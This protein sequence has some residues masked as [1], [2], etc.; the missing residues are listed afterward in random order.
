MLR[1]DP[2]YRVDNRLNSHLRGMVLCFLGL[3]WTRNEL[4]GPGEPLTR[5]CLS[6]TGVRNISC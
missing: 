2:I 1:W 6:Y 4:G 5:I 3:K